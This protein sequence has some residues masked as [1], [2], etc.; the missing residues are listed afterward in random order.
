MSARSL[1][2]AERETTITA[3]DADDEV[4]IWT[5]QRRYLGRLRRDPRFTEVRSGFHG[6]TAWG[7]F[8]IAADH[9]TPNGG[10]K[11]VRKGPMS[12][13]QRAALLDRLAEYRAGGPVEDEADDENE[14]TP[15]D[16]A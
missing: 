13:A 7:E 3:T 8:V 10:A 16:A 12:D 15:E 2:A 1:S 4:R 14:A 11:R 6:E 9:W 5:C